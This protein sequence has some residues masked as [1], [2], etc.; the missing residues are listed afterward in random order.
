MGP[1]HGPRTWPPHM[2]PHMAMTKGRVMSHAAGTGPG[3][4]GRPRPCN[5]P[6]GSVANSAMRVASPFG[7]ALQFTAHARGALVLS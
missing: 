7:W 5:T 6:G 2:A 1:A 3:S 4:S